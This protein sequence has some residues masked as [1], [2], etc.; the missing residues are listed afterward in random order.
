M[1]QSNIY[2]RHRFPPAI[3]QY[4]VWLYLRFNISH[5]DIEGPLAERGIS[6][7]YDAIRTESA[8]EKEGA[9]LWLAFSREVVR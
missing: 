6:V 2:K 7:S 3:I 1:N 8:T 5:R 4:A 9:F